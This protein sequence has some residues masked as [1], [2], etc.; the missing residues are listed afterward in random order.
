MQTS[1]DLQLDAV[2]DDESSIPATTSDRRITWL[3]KGFL[4]LLDQGLLSGSNFFIAILLARWLTRDEYGAYAMGFSIFILLSGFHNSFF[5]E[6]MSVFGPESYAGCLGAY[7]KKLLGFHF[8]FTLFLS[9]LAVVG[10]LLLPYFMNDRGLTSA[11]WG[12]CFAVPLILFYWLCRRAAYLK[13]APGLAVIGSATY[14]AASLVLVVALRKWLSPFMGFLI[15]ALAAI[16][17]VIVLLA[18][19]GSR[20]DPQPSPANPEV[21]RRHWRYGRWVLGS[22]I[23]NWVSGYAYYVIVGA[24]LPM[25]DV[26]ALRALRNL[27][28]PCYRAMAAIILL[29]LPWASSRLVEE[30]IQ[31]LQRRTR[32]LNMLFG[33]CALAYFAALCLFGNRVMGILYAGRYNGSSHLLVLATAPLVFIAASLGSEIAVQVMQAPSEVFLAYGAS[34]ALT[35]ILGIAFTHYWGLVGGLVSI[36]I[37]SA[38]VWVVLTYRCRKRLQAIASKSSRVPGVLSDG[39]NLA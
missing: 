12:V 34:G 9:A 32:Q 11:I 35:F 19:L 37:S 14:C 18:S 10:V 8:V 6:P 31:G 3:R 15:Q 39:M 27:T 22:T 23:V 26:A 24:L 1:S 20:V 38:T 28:E 33:G 16:P 13:F 25:Q 36:L 29:V 21:L 5:L 7:V 2:I 4:A 17:A 30:G